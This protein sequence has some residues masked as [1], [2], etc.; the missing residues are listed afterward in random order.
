MFRLRLKKR[1]IKME[2]LILISGKQGSGK[3]TLSDYLTMCI[4]REGFLVSPIK[5]ADPLYAMHEKCLLVLKMY[6]IRPMDM[7]K[8]GELL[9]VLGTEYGRE[10]LGVD[11]WAKT[12]FKR[13]QHFLSGSKTH[14]A[15]IDDCRFENE[16]LFFPN[17]YRIRL[18]ASETLRKQRCSYWR[19]NTKH[20]SEIGL[21]SFE[22]QGRFDAVYTTDCVRPEVLA[23]TVWND[24]KKAQSRARKGE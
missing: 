6:G 4:N 14:F 22:S 10:K 5:F 2:N 18:S 24:F 17:A 20:P 11:V 9:Q 3:S 7:A 16:F 8:D 13:V 15:I 23:E 12:A 19:E 1:Q 21:D